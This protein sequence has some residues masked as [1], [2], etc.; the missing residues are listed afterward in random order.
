MF[1]LVFQGYAM[2]VFGISFL[3]GGGGVRSLST[4]FS[5]PSIFVV[6]KT[7]VYFLYEII[8]AWEYWDR[9]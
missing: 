9:A 4:F 2:W 5:F 3:P 7:V 1:M 8:D 6:L